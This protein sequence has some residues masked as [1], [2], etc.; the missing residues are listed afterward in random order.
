MADRTTRLAKLT[1]PAGR[2]QY[3]RT[4]LFELLDQHMLSP[5]LWIAGPPG[6]GK[7]T[8]IADYSAR[9][10]LNGLWYQIDRGDADVA[11]SFYYLAEAAR[12]NGRKNP[13][14]P[15]EPSYQGDVEAFARG[16]FREL[17]DGD[18]PY[19]VFDNYQALRADAHGQ[20][21]VLMAMN[22]LPAGGRIFVI[23]RTNPP[24]GFAAARAR[25]QM[26][27]VGWDELRMS[28]EECAGVA[29]A[30]DVRIS[31]AELDELHART[32]GWA[33]GMVL[34]LQGLRHRAA[35]KPG[36]AGASGTAPSVIFD[37]LAEEIF[38]KFAPPVQE[39]LLR[40]AYLPQVTTALAAALGPGDEVREAVRDFT[41][42]EFLVTVVQREP[43][44]VFQ[45]HPLL[46]EFLVARAE[47]TGDSAQIE[48][49]RQTVAELLA[50]H[51]YP[52]DAAALFIR[53]R[54][55]AAL[56]R[57]I[58]EAADRL[59]EH[60]RTQTL[61]RWIEALP[62][63][64]ASGDAWLGYWLGAARYPYAPRE[65]VQL[66]AEAY[67]KFSAFN[68][69]DVRGAVSALN[70][71]IE[72]IICDAHDFTLLDP[73]IAEAAAWPQALQEHPTPGIEARFTCTAFVAMALRQ[74]Q[75]LDLPA[76][77]DRAIALVQ[78]RSDPNVR[79]ALASALTALAAWIGQF[80]RV[81][82][83]IEMMHR[84]LEK[85]EISPA[86]ATKA[87]QAESMYWML[88]GDRERCVAASLHGL[89]I[90]EHTGVRLWNDTFLINALCGALA[91]SDLKSAAEFLQQIE[92][93]T[94]PDRK[95]DMALHSYATAWYAMLQGDAFLAHRRLKLGVRTAAELGLPFFQ[96]I[97]GIGL[98]MV[99]AENGDER[100]AQAEL[101]RALQ[102]AA[103]IRNRLLDF[104]VYMCRAQMALHRDAEAEALE[105][106]RTG[107]Q[108]GRE[109]GFMHFLWWQP[110]PVARLCQKALEAD[111]ER[112]Y[113]RRLILQRK[114][115][116]EPPPY[117]LAAWPWRYRI[118]VLGNYKLTRAL[119]V[120]GSTARR[121]GRPVELLK[122][123]VA[124]GGESVRLDRAAEALWPHVDNDYALKS[125]TT[126]LFRLRK[127]FAE[128][129][130][131]LVA[132][133]ELSLNRYY[134]WID[135][136]AF[137]QA[138]DTVFS[139]RTADATLEAA[140]TALAHYRGPLLADAEESWTVA[141][142]ERHR[143]LLQRLLSTVTGPLEKQGR[144]DDALA[145][146]RHA[147]ELDPL[148]EPLHRR[149][150]LIL[151]NSGRVPEALEA[152][153]RCRALLKAEGGAEPSAATQE[154]CRS[155][156]PD[157]AGRP[158]A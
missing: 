63:G 56:T 78:T 133:G 141:P 2:A 22:E 36:A 75:H 5:V 136:W 62:A 18:A 47:E 85:P 139:A 100:G 90:V 94:T 88:A 50:G 131:L 45:F 151:K 49:R 65:A 37:Y 148:C 152:C 143:S 41:S 138:C 34:L 124:F 153:Q 42:T 142:R 23:S 149:V 92:A 58:R 82:P 79:I 120:E 12:A 102:V 9:R 150:I 76:W 26:T 119:P 154:L 127:E 61:Q 35:P 46:R 59:L 123:L 43:Q 21:I 128:E 67:R 156:L 97:A 3:A 11:S 144:I 140:R 52:E 64:H 74:P 60:G 147:L 84:L 77:R 118:E 107:L 134:F 27:V 86:N 103:T 39:F 132:D 117:Q 57:V 105:L 14:P 87:A 72:A 121:G 89:A 25:G 19:L 13:L 135:T 137:E 109:R 51:G 113:V 40:A 29:A 146:Y 53:N 158:P 98:A 125:L 96:V 115:M 1:R 83:L 38:T 110:R 106:L 101:S 157:A 73:W 4:R 114:L 70:Y 68:P 30:R 129:D 66:F 116:P 20:D 54:D 95:F 93:R 6:A 55:W 99:L 91:D 16:F 81:E 69:P 122:V 32:Q 104:T 126:T 44:L 8:L 17:F 48:A 31:D 108:I 28:R 33:A 15:F 130:A 145:L 24:A 80:A 7:T 155:L 71:L 112:E 111:I 10:G